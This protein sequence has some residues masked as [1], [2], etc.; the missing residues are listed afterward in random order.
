MYYYQV[1]SNN[2]T[3]VS[4]CNEEFARIK[5]RTLMGKTIVLSMLPEWKVKKFKPKFNAKTR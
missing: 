5:G 4:T 1:S 3:M 2:K